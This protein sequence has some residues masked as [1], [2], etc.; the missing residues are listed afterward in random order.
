[1][2]ALLGIG[3]HAH[4][5]QQHSDALDDVMEYVPHAAVYML[6]ACGVDSRDDWPTLTLTT[7]AA[8][9]ASAGTAFV[10]KRCISESRPDGSDNRSFPSGHTTMAFSGA[11]MLHKEFGKTSPWIS[12]AGYGI[13][14]FVGIDRVLRD[15]HYWHD[16][17][18]GAAIG[19][20]ATELTWWLSRK[21]FKSK[22]PQVS[23]GFGGNT[24]DVAVNL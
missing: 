14:T 13:A 16:V 9:V 3:I 4:A 5:Q 6:K 7:A 17:V 12:V 21:V 20:A 24:V 22:N 8:W 23:I 11:L 15:R 1:M 18:A 2:I 10:L 19:T